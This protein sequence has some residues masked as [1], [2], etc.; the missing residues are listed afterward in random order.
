MKKHEFEVIPLEYRYGIEKIEYVSYPDK[1]E[2]HIYYS[3]L[4]IESKAIQFNN[5]YVFFYDLT[6]ETQDNYALKLYNLNEG[7]AKRL[8]L[9]PCKL[10]WWFEEHCHD[11]DRA[12]DD[13]ENLI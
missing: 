9:D 10:L 8:N 2:E 6:E 1:G 12:I 5:E 4:N 13:L 3:G 11:V 7:I